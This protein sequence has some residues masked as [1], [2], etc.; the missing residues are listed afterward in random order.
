MRV[1]YIYPSVD[2]Y[3]EAFKDLFSQSSKGGSIDDIRVYKKPVGGNLFGILAKVLQTSLPF[4]KRLVMPEVRGF[5]N[6][7]MNDMQQNVPIR[8]SLKKNLKTSAKNI[9]KRILRGGAR[10]KRKIS[11]K[12]KKS[13]IMKRPKKT[14]KRKHCSKTKSDI[15][16]SGKFDL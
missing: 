15:F 10:K 11:S 9:G 4:V 14:R 12:R 7:F 16:N 8:Q 1:Q 2:L 3:D 13:K 5:A 6:N